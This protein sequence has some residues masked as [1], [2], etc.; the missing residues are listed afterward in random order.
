MAAFSAKHYI[1]NKETEIAQNQIN[2]RARKAANPEKEKVRQQVQNAKY[3]AKNR[4]KCMALA[5]AWAKAN[6][7]KVTAERQK[8][9]AEKRGNAGTGGLLT[10][11]EWTETKEYFDH[12]CAYCGRQL[13]KLTI[14]HIVPLSHGGMHA[15]GNIVPA[16]RSCNSA[17]HDSSLLVYLLRRA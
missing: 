2:R 5:A 7:D 9:R 10:A 12:R 1:N 4:D 3:Y 17:K 8:R 6:P 16:C 14:D 11:T 13:E 15:R